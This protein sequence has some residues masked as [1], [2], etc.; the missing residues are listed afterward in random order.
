MAPQS[1]VYRRFAASAQGIAAVEFAIIMPILLLLFLA[2]LDGGRALAIYMKVRAATFTLASITNQYTTI[3]STDMQQ[4]VGAASVVLTP[5]PSSPA[6]VTISQL[7]LNAAGNATVSWSYSLNGT[8][9]TQGATMT[10]PGTLVPANSP[11][12]SYP[13]YFIFSEV[14]Y[15]YTPLFG[16]LSSSAINLADNLYV[17]PRSSSCVLYPPGNVTS[18]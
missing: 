4:I 18:C 8:A 3:Q 12:S 6:V 13:C 5:Y 16:Y 1:R 15:S 11:C 14:S 17:T 10:L 2:S 9:H 7:S